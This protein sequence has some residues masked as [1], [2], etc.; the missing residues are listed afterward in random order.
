MNKSDRPVL[1]I[2]QTSKQPVDHSQSCFATW[3]GSVQKGGR[4]NAG[5][6]LDLVED[7][8]HSHA[9]KPVGCAH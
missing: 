8:E 2:H 4:L 9:K 1:S 7:E 3:Q 5:E 6:A